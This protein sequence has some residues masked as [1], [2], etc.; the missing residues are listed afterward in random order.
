MT[1]KSPTVPEVWLRGPIDGVEPTLMPAVHAL[2]QVSEDIE[3]VV[4]AL[5]PAELWTTPAGAASIGFHVRHIAGSI[6]RL[7]TY[8]RGESLS[9]EQ[10]DTLDKE[11]EQGSPADARALVDI[12]R[13]AIEDAIALMRSV[14]RERLHER[15][16][17]GRAALPSTVLGLLFHAA[18]HAQRHTGQIITTAKVARARD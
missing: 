7:C 10:R 15:R 1:S 8:A 18:E 14:P 13:K 16:T 9:E 12:A 17:V 3:R 4:S 5:T 6:D 2:I 11:K